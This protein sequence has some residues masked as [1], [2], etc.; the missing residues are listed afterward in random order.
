MT[1]EEFQRLQSNCK[2]SD[3]YNPVWSIYH[4]DGF[5]DDLLPAVKLLK[6]KAMEVY[7]GAELFT[8]IVKTEQKSY[9]LTDSKY[10]ISLIAFTYPKGTEAAKK[11]SNAHFTAHSHEVCV[12]I[13]V[14]QD[15]TIDIFFRFGR[16]FREF[17][18]EYSKTSKRIFST[19]IIE[20][21]IYKTN[22]KNLKAIFDRKLVHYNLMEFML[23]T[24]GIDEAKTFQN[25]YTLKL[26][27]LL[28]A[29]KIRKLKYTNVFGNDEKK[30]TILI[31]PTGNESLDISLED[32]KQSID[33]DKSQSSIAFLYEGAENYVVHE[34]AETKPYTTAP[35]IINDN[36]KPTI[37]NELVKQ[38]HEK[39]QN[40]GLSD[41]PKPPQQ[42]QTEFSFADFAQLLNEQVQKEFY[43]N[44]KLKIRV[45]QLSESAATN[46]KP[47]DQP[48]TAQIKPSLQVT[49]EAIIQNYEEWDVGLDIIIDEKG[50]VSVKHYV[51][52]DYL[53][54]SKY[55]TQEIKARGLGE[56]INLENLRQEI[57]T[58]FV[59]P[60]TEECFSQKFLAAVDKIVHIPAV[61]KTLQKISAATAKS[62]A[63]YVEGVQ[64]TQ[65]VVKNVWDEG[66]INESIWWKNDTTGEYQQWPEYM[67]TAPVVG[68][69]VDGVIDEIVGIPLAIRSVYEIATDEEKREG[70]K[71][72]FTKEG[73]DKLKES[74]KE[75]VKT[76]INDEDKQEHFAG[77]T[78]VNVAAMF[79]GFSIFTKG[80]KLGELLEKTTG[81]IKK[82]SAKA[83]KSFEDIRNFF[84]HKPNERKKLNKHFEKYDDIRKNDLGEQLAE[85]A[86][87]MHRLKTQ[88]QKF[89]DGKDYEEGIKQLIKKGDTKYLQEVADKAGITLD[90]LKTYTHL[91]Q[92]Q[93]R[94]PNTNGGFTTMDNV[95]VKKVTDTKTGKTYLEAIINDCKLSKDAPFSNRQLQFEKALDNADSYFDLR[96]TKFEQYQNSTEKIFQN[97]EIRVKVYLKTVGEGGSPPDISKFNINKIK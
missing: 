19:L 68:G 28:C 5:A 11:M 90:E 25:N 38:I 91:D 70:F 85:E 86:D 72:M 77:K 74:L 92:V 96:N 52:P 49:N 43:K 79:T 53:K 57:V 87:E 37:N 8:D 20:D 10:L 62:V 82:F 18:R 45:V 40:T 50:K 16:N 22:I 3:F 23:K 97:T 9:K 4:S 73:F 59:A 93:I 64:A 75:E 34:P 95:W 81:Y 84:K 46:L 47:L 21:N 69:A 29:N 76:I 58:N 66:E 80:G 26:S 2:P 30:Q 71:A 55:W 89:I 60:E 6:S 48:F 54:E 24:I 17:L 14:A 42:E 35:A 31:E 1:T 63:A 78:T 12:F 27:R 39:A 44:V 41:T 94:I 65:K 36:N 56:E 83:A 33:L 7:D 88:P 13:E 32:E 51:S 61:Q 67:H 15:G